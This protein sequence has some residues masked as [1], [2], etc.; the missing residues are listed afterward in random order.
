[1]PIDRIVGV[2]RTLTFLSQ[3]SRAVPSAIDGRQAD[4]L[5][6]V[7]HRLRSVTIGVVGIGGLGSPTAEQLVRMG[8]AEV[9][10]L[11]HDGPR[12]EL[13]CAQG[14]RSPYEGSDYR[15]T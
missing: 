3:V 1:M 7:H 4:A 13:Q 12:Y 5:G 6:V 8:A 9:I 14:I 2:G 10:L 15:K 11:D